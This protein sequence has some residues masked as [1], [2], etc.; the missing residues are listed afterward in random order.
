M[1]ARQLGA[2]EQRAGGQRGLMA[3]ALALEQAAR[4]MA[5]NVVLCAIAPRAA[6]PIRLA[7]R[8]DRHT[9][10]VFAAVA[11]EELR[12][13]HPGLELDSVHWHGW[14]LDSDRSHRRGRQAHTVRQA[15]VRDESGR[16]LLSVSH[17]QPGVPDL[18]KLPGVLLRSDK[19][20][21][22]LDAH[23]L[24]REIHLGS[25]RMTKTNKYNDAWTR[26]LA[27]LWTAKGEGLRQRL[28]DDPKSVFAEYGVEFPEGVNVNVIE[29]SPSNFNFVIPL[30]PSG[31]ANISDADIAELYQA[32]PGTQLDFGG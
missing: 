11:G 5:P 16:S 6:K 19:D 22:R 3:T 13:R 17:Q 12:H 25:E 18:R 32:C 28:R 4:A 26:L 10:L 31:L 27:A 15:E 30:V 23:C 21:C 7:H 24:P 20:C 8:S 9:A 14:P 2:V 29:N 1:C